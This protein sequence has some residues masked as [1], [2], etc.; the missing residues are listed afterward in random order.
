MGMIRS[1]IGMVLLSVLAI[2]CNTSKQATNDITEDVTAVD[3]ETTENEELVE[4]VEET[5]PEFA[6]EPTHVFFYTTAIIREDGTLDCYDTD[7]GPY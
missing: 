7:D 4:E 1:M 2:G 6:L 5:E 3:D